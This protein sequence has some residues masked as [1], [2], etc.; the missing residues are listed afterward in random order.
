MEHQESN[1]EKGDQIKTK[2][3]KQEETKKETQIHE[4]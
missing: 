3:Q 2:E 4:K 1:H